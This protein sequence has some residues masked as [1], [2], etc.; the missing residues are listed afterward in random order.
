MYVVARVSIEIVT[1][2]RNKSTIM[3]CRLKLLF[4]TIR[5]LKIKQ[6]Y[7]RIYYRFKKLKPLFLEKGST[8]TLSYQ[9]DWHGVCY[10]PQSVFNDN[11]AKFLN[12]TASIKATT[13]WNDESK[14]KLWLYNL[15]YLDDLNSVG[16]EDRCE[17]HLHFIHRWID[18]NP[19][20][21]GSGWVPY[22][23]SLRLVNLVKWCCRNK[24][25]DHKILTSI[26]QQ[27]DALEQQFEYH[28]LANHLF[29]NAKALVFIGVFL[30]DSLGKKFLTKGLH[31][32]KQEMN[33]QFLS[34]GAH[35]ELSPMYH[36]V[37]LW[38]VLE[39]IDLAV[40]TSEQTL[41]TEINQWKKIA[42]KGIYWLNSMCHPD[43]EISFFND[44]ASGIAPRP[45]II[46]EYANKL[47]ICKNVISREQIVSM[48]VSGYTRV[49]LKSAG[50][51]LLINHTEIQ[52]SYQPGHAHADTLSF[53]L[54]LLGHRVFVNTGTS[55]YGL[56]D[57]RNRQRSTL[58]H[59]TLNIDNK[60][61]SE[62]WNGFRVARRA[63]ITEYSYNITEEKQIV[64]V[65][66]DGYTRI[67]KSLIHQRMFT[68]EKGKLV[69]SDSLANANKVNANARYHIHPSV[70]I[71]KFS[72]SSA[73]LKLP[74][75]VVVEVKVSGGKMSRHMYNYFPE[76]GLKIGSEFIEVRMSDS[77]LDFIITWK[78]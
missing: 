11:T 38:D 66:H 32:L 13:I 10:A 77:E 65:A 24:V 62:V 74:N 53:E 8:V 78:E 35:F 21:H 75:D 28:I 6:I 72:D 7:F 20:V 23:L 17:Q 26:L 40:I 36:S 9:F 67:D 50:S 70:K 22:T 43:D 25:Y 71:V 69:I 58:S 49:N 34:D 51:V 46:R 5:Y 60:D 39:L 29:A 12:E 27:A 55:Q 63:K 48:Q 76:F 37:L 4:N 2:L 30:G 73:Q 56:G 18:E 64:S 42:E 57:E 54:S 33:E 59:N 41:A 68:S 52:P 19:P 47:G 45:A 16:A 44:A 3:F 15:H 61:S 31:V 14:E 1:L